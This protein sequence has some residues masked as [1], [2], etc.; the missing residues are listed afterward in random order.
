[1]SNHVDVV[2]TPLPLIVNTT[3]LVFETTV[4]CM[5]NMPYNDLIVKIKEEIESTSK[6]EYI[7]II[8]KYRT[9]AIVMEGLLKEAIIFLESLSG[10]KVDYKYLA[11][12]EA[13]RLRELISDFHNFNLNSDVFI[14]PF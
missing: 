14:R 13:V 10:K 6:G 9:Q 1:M 12:Q 7:K 8:D 3:T 4:D 5:H 2:S 11:S